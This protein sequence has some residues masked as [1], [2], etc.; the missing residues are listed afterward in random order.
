MT[1]LTSFHLLSPQIDD[2]DEIFFLLPKSHLR[3]LTNTLTK[4]NVDINIENDGQSSEDST[5]WTS[6]AIYMGLH[7]R[8]H[9]KYSRISTSHMVD[10]ESNLFSSQRTDLQYDPTRM[11]SI[12]LSFIQKLKKFGF[13]FLNIC[14]LSRCENFVEKNYLKTFPSFSYIEIETHHLDRQK[15]F[16]L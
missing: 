2:D 12:C 8:N 5:F 15:L 6:P 10:H 14:Q 16:L 3:K 13:L 1:N 7:W 9:Y 11:D 4:Q